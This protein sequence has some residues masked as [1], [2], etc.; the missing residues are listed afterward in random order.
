MTGSTGSGDYY[1]FAVVY[2][3]DSNNGFLGLTPIATLAYVPYPGFSFSVQAGKTYYIQGGES[4]PYGWASTLGL[5]LEV[6][7]PPP[8]D[9]FADAISI[10]STPYSDSQN[11]AAATVESGEP[12]ACGG[13][14]TQSTWYAFTPTTTGTYG[15]YGVSGV[16]VYTGS[17]LSNLTSIACANWPG[18]YFHA[19]AGTTYYLQSYSGWVSVDVVAPPNADFTYSPGDP[20]IFDNASFSYWNGGYWDPTMTGYAWTF[21]DGATGT[22]QTMSHKFSKD[23]DY[24]VTITVSA[25]GDR[26]NS[27]TK[28]VQ[29]RTHDVSILSLDAPK[30][31]KLGKQGVITVGIGNLRY[32]ENVQVDVYK[33]TPNGNVLTN[34]GIQSVGV[35]KAKQTRTFS[36][37]YTF[38]QDDL[39]LGKVVFQAVATI[40][41][42]RDSLTLDNSAT[43]TPTV[44]TK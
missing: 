21:S 8:N 7:P 32:P 40:Q 44:V 26:T 17:S 20:S 29:V 3:A 13:P 12:M 9:N 6:I 36:F 30:K 43:S 42:A 35:M 24:T 22:D 41:G 39:A 33:V 5:H 11:M 16:N 28:T 38:T 14:F 10:T 25:L 31:G 34:T 19:N 27:A 15:G 2:R 4:D 37:N 18:L 1:A 23:G